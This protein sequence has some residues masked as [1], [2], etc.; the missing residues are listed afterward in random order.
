MEYNSISFVTVAFNN[1]EGLKR[2]WESVKSLSTVS[3]KFEWLVIDGGFNDDGKTI[4]FLKSLGDSVRWVSEPDAGIY[5]AMN[6]G[7]R[8]A[9]MRFVNFLNAGDV[10]IADSFIKTFDAVKKSSEV[11][12]CAVLYDYGGFVKLREPRSLNY[13]RYGMPANH[14][15]CIY[16]KDFISRFPYPAEYRISAD[17][18]LSTVIYLK[19]PV[20]E[21]F[22]NPI[23]SF[24]VGGVS[25]VKFNRVVREMFVIQRDVLKIGLF[26]RVVFAV[27]R[28]LVMTA[29]LVI[30]K[31]FHSHKK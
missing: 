29:N 17:Y 13:A 25:T 12:F 21:Y 9:S 18:W 2:T 16:R 24:E 31:I 4:E 8:L 19:K 26:E 14:Q 27:R 22:K 20:I 5:D 6:K 1:S 10:L 30:Y 7:V 11:I 23:V 28:S 15:G 3:L